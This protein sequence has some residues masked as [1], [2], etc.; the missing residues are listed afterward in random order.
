MTN[1]QRPLQNSDAILGHVAS[2]GDRYPR[3]LNKLPVAWAVNG[4]RTAA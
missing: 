1:M 4:S 2:R 3:T